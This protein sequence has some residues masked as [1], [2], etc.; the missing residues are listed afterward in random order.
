[1]GS[2]G[3]ACWSPC[4]P[5]WYFP[6]EGGGYSFIEQVGLL[7]QKETVKNLS[8][9]ATQTPLAPPIFGLRRDVGELRGLLISLAERE[10]NVEQE[11]INKNI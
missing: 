6:Q 10:G 11:V 1:M 2:P 8:Q 4:S 3:F 9:K 5:I 7:W